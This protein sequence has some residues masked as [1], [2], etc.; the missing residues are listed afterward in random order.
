MTY[1][2]LRDKEVVNAR[3]GK[4]LGCICDLELDICSGRILKIILP[5]YGSWFCFKN[6]KS[7]IYIP[8]E[9]IE[10]IGD[11]VIIVRCRE[12]FECKKKR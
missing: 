6:C 10:R 5:P 7:K 4:V 3:D 2:A 1:E 12:V 8:W 9:D 11:D